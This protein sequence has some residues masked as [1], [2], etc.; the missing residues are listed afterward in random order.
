MAIVQDIQDMGERAPLGERRPMSQDLISCP[1]LTVTSL[2][3]SSS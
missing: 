2:I 1:E 3:K